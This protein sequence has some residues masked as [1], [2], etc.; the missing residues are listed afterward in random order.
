MHRTANL[1]TV[2]E[3]TRLLALDLDAN[4]L[5]VEVAAV[6]G[7]LPRV[8]ATQRVLRMGVCIRMFSYR[9]YVMWLLMKPLCSR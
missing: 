8:L 4:N 7:M 3:G 5:L 1:G 2:V 6:L 9:V